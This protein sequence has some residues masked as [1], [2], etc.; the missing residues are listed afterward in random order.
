MKKIIVIFAS[1]SVL[2]SCGNYDYKLAELNNDKV[3]FEQLPTEV[4][5]V[6]FNRSKYK[7]EGAVNFICLDDSNNYSFETIKTWI[8]PWEAYNKLTDNKK[9]IS[10]LIETDKPFPY[11]VFKNK[12]YLPSKYNTL[13]T[14]KDFSILEFYIF[15][16]KENK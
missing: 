5:N 15:E 13:F 1:I 2:F 12:F 8:G 14:A 9:E 3:S 4:Q 6:Y 11:L 7:N 16:L 10:Y